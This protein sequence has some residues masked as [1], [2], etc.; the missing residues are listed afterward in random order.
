MTVP[1]WIALLAL[2]AG[3]ALLPAAASGQ[4]ESEPRQTADSVLKDMRPGETT[5]TVTEIDYFDPADPPAK[6]PAVRKVEIIDPKGTVIDT[7]VPELCTA[8]DGELMAQG[9]EACPPGSQVGKGFLRL[10][11]GL[12]EPGRF[13]EADIVLL[14]NTDQLIFLSTIRGSGAV[15]VTRS[16]L[17]GRTVTTEVPMLPGTPPDGAAL[18][19]ARTKLRPISVDRDGTEASYVRTPSRC[20]RRGFWTVEHVFTYSDGEAQTVES[21]TPCRKRGPR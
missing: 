15:V 19:L 4:A 9:A 5:A 2:I 13:L 3:A 17:V 18:D 6:P 8:S 10:D 14:N 21:R 7:S 11:T 16:S 1:R 12:P 20:P